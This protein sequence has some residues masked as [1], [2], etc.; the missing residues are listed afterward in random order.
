M[1]YNV[2]DFAFNIIY[3]RAK[4][5]LGKRI[6]QGV[7][8]MTREEVKKKIYDKK[9]K[10]ALRSYRFRP[11]KNFIFWVAGV[12]SSIAV[13]AGAIFVGVKVV[14]ISTYTGGVENEYVSED[15]SS[16]S[17]LDALLTFNQMDFADIP[18]VTDMLFN[19][20]DGADIEK[21]VTIDREK[22]NDVSFDFTAGDEQGFVTALL[23]CVTLNPEFLGDI[24][25]LTV[26]TDYQEVPSEKVEEVIDAEEGIKKADDGTT[27]SANPKNYYY[28]ANESGTQG[29]GNSPMSAQGQTTPNYKRAFN[30][31]GT[32][33][34][35]AKGKK[36]Y[37]PALKD[38]PIMDLTGMI[39]EVMARVDIGE[40]VAIAM[41]STDSSDKDGLT[42]VLIES[43]SGQTLNGLDNIASTLLDGITLKSIAGEQGKDLLA[44]F[45]TLSVFEWGEKVP[46]EEIEVNI[47]A[48]GNIKK[49]I[50]E[51]PEGSGEPVTEK[52]AVNPKL[53]Y[54]LDNGE[55][56]KAFDENG[57]RVEGAEGV[58][59]FYYA[60]LF[61]A[62]FSDVLELF[63]DSF[64]RV[65]ITEIFTAADLKLEDGNP[66][67][68]IFEGMKIGE[69]GAA[70]LASDLLSKINLDALG[71][72][73]ALGDF[74]TLKI[75]NEW[76]QVKLEDKPVLTENKLDT[77]K[78]NV[79]LFYYVADATKIKDGVYTDE[80]YAKAFDEKGEFVGNDYSATDLYYAKLSVVGFSD[81]A[82]LIGE[83]FSRI[84]LMGLLE[85]FGVEDLKDNKLIADLFEGT[86]I[87]D[88]AN[89]LSP[90][91][92]LDSI[93]LES[94]GGA[95]ALGDFGSLDIFSKWQEVKAEDKPEIDGAYKLDTK[96]YNVNLFYYIAD[97][98]KIKDG[99]YTDEAYAKAF[100]ENGEFVGN[101]Y[102]AT[103]LYYAKLSAVGFGDMTELI[104]ES[105]SRIELMSLLKT[106]GVENLEDNKLIADLFEGTTIGDLANSLS[107][108]KILDSI[109]LES[110]GGAAALGDFGS[111]KMFSQWEI[112]KQ[113]DMPIS[114]GMTSINIEKYN[115]KLY[116]FLANNTD[117]D[118]K[119]HLKDT[120]YARAFNDDGTIAD[121]R[122]SAN[123]TL[124]YA[125]LSAVGFGDMTD[126]I[127]ESFN[128]I[129]VREL[130]D[131]M[132]D[133]PISADDL[134]GK[135]LGD[136][137]ISEIGK[138]GTAED[139]IYLSWVIPFNDGTT[140]NSETYRLI[141]QAI[142]NDVTDANLETL[143]NK[144]T[145]TDL[146]GNFDFD[147]VKLTSVL[148][149]AG[150]ETLYR[151][152]L[153]ATAKDGE[154]ITDANVADK[155]NAFTIASLSSGF[156]INKIKLSTV[157]TTVDDDM[158]ELLVQLFPAAGSYENITIASLSGSMSFDGVKLTTVLPYIEYKADG[159]TIEK[160]NSQ[161][162]NILLQ[163]TGKTANEQN[164]KEF[165]I[166]DLSG[167][168]DMNKINLS[169]VLGDSVDE[170]MK[171]LL[172]QLF[173]DTYSNL[174][175]GKLGGSMSFDGIKLTTVLPYIEYKADGVTIEKDNSQLYNILLQAT[176]KTANEQNAKEFKIADLNGGFDMNKINLSTVLGDSVDEDMQDLL[177]QLF[178]GSYSQFTVATLGGEISFDNV[179][180][181]KFVDESTRE[182]IA[183]AINV[184]REAQL[185]DGQ[186]LVKVNAD[187]T[188][189]QMKEFDSKYI[190]LA[191][192]MGSNVDE[193]MK[194]LLTQITGVE[195]DKITVSSLSGEMS[196]SGVYL[197]TVLPYSANKNIF[198]ILLEAAGKDAN[199]T[200]AKNF[201]IG[202]ISGSGFSINNVKLETV[203]TKGE[204]NAKL[205]EIL[206]S[207][208]DKG[209]DGVLNLGDLSKFNLNNLRLTTVI[210]PTQSNETLFNILREATG[211]E[212][213]DEIY[214]SALNSFSF[215]GVRLGT[216]LTEPTGNDMLEAL[217]KDDSVTLSNIG[218]KLN[219][220]SLY[221]VYGKNCF[222][223]MSAGADQIA[224]DSPKFKALYDG[225]KIIG[226]EH[227]ESV[228]GDDA[229]YL[230]KDDGIWLLLCFKGESFKE[231]FLGDNPLTPGVVE[232][233]YWMDTDGRPE[234]YMISSLT[235]GALQ[236]DASAVSNAILGATIR[237]LVD[238]GMLESTNTKIYPLTMQ[239]VI[240]N[241]K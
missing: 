231:T 29:G 24:G 145:I 241:M 88:L 38:V 208:V 60:N 12:I 173:N 42:S 80:A 61:E 50:D 26:M 55:Y 115:P 206:E 40:V 59:D 54:Y 215:S 94:L 220:L 7:I 235:L 200:N 104:G 62:P 63:G 20:L 207:T 166:A 37:Y 102:A 93:T 35:E 185:E 216:V 213:N 214:V 78:Y 69:L 68:T 131:S 199:E 75:F 10:K 105:F 110:L 43:L 135:I 219:N 79:N 32:W 22:L 77:E 155:A 52:F 65:E 148:D 150:N 174:T 201:T 119:G 125:K 81:M 18:G 188:V 107:P 132:S 76:E 56:F 25:P 34:A 57:V 205:F 39:D 130:I 109:T 28:D 147:K 98:T 49:V 163:A 6:F 239:G 83:S 238:A 140:D 144:L 82:D 177:E 204:D 33:V 203:L 58:S 149:Y 162:Y 128:R 187:L 64:S 198:N 111:L 87:G 4:S 44:S 222:V 233:D 90:E 223:H 230:H 226:F 84:E 234:K 170:D 136:K 17:I 72:T 124:Y 182:L 194:S 184:K 142:G 113:E 190:R 120:A 41:Q 123:T 106:F 100:D 143:A 8:I 176:G 212:N 45:G 154:I 51:S 197:N 85:T 168:F 165:K 15:V 103:T 19:F 67:A 157:M 129:P 191:K 116:Y 240:D 224:L 89:D 95:A 237:Q 73:E 171:T 122:V 181:G 66:I 156:D 141:L 112:V 153:E 14:P 71:G 121:A 211:A 180:L 139:P 137:S 227:D 186:T 47:D 178:G 218:S 228:S 183:D 99:V 158:K 175:V 172:E 23:D 151:I 189:S 36:L 164:A 91:K 179:K 97:A 117:V 108:E 152:L 48:N 126:L 138:I 225:E 1:C 3:V 118:D 196:F 86:T 30:N 167:G 101:D 159:V 96:K 229:W 31:D 21:F 2:D 209:A 9:V 92:I 192:V 46:Q 210:T 74:G 127:G 236:T 27:F 217:R 160:D 5:T 161:L 134:I 16:K 169:T 133:T 221:E 202:E 195:F 114:E 146:S 11:F 193:D 232:T 13:V 53:Y 70:D